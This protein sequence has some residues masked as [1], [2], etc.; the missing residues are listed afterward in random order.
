MKIVVSRNGGQVS[1]KLLDQDGEP[2]GAMPAM[3][4]L[5]ADPKEI[6]LERSLKAAEDGT[7]RFQAIRPGKYR[8]LAFESD[9]FA[10][11]TDFLESVKKLAAAAEEIEIKE[12]DRKVKDL[13]LLAKGDADGK[14]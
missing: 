4:L 13:K 2:L 11:G 5:A 10:D 12:G 3:V 9:Q 8:L 14:P 6:D 1:G 7:Y